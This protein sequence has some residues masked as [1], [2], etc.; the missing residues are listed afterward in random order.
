MDDVL[1]ACRVGDFV[2]VPLLVDVL[3]EDEDGPIPDEALGDR[4]DGPTLVEGLDDE[5][6]GPTVVGGLDDEDDVSTLEDVLAEED[7][8]FGPPVRE[9]EFEDEDNLANDFELLGVIGGGAGCCCW[10][11]ELWC[12]WDD[13]GWLGDVLVLWPDSI[14]V[15]TEG[16]DDDGE[17]IEFVPLERMF[18]RLPLTG[19]KALGDL[20]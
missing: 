12:D 17:D 10:G 4:D 8:L 15:V 3:S 18:I 11:N 14:V 5:D 13:P 19:R 1:L 2:F 7:L 20:E 16:A 9:D 6:D